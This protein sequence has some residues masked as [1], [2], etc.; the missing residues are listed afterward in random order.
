MVNKED[1]F[2]FL[3]DLRESGR[4]NMF[5]AVP[6]VQETFNLKRYDARDIVI[7]WMESFTR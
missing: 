2:S 5:G 7:E 6:V 1:V 4:I 3:N